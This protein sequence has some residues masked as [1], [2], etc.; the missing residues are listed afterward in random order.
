MAIFMWSY[1]EAGLNPC[2]CFYLILLCN[3]FQKQMNCVRTDLYNMREKQLLTMP[4]RCI[5]LQ[6]SSLRNPLAKHDRHSQD[7]KN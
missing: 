1:K 7:T 5:Y 6:F 2:E 3:S 4:D